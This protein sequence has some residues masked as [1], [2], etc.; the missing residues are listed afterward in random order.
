MQYSEAERKK[1]INKLKTVKDARE[2][3][4]IIWALAGQ[5]EKK[6]DDAKPSP[7]AV[8]R[9]KTSPGKPVP[10]GLQN[11]PGVAVDAKLL[12]G[13]AVPVFFLI[14]GITYIIQSILGY[15]ATRRIEEEMSGLLMGVIFVIVGLV[16]IF[17]ALRS[18]VK[19]PDR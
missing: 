12:V 1:L 15:L 16:G 19:A 13:M 5:E 17:K 4:R 2:R 11:L 3:D 7:A 18:G 8:Q 10:R 9:G 14:F 6:S